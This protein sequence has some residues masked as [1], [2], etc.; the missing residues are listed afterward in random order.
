MKIHGQR[1][2]SLPVIKQ[3]QGVQQ[4]PG[5]QAQQQQQQVSLQAQ[6]LTAQPGLQYDTHQPPGQQEQAC[7][8]KIPAAD[9]RKYNLPPRLQRHG[10]HT[11]SRGYRDRPSNGG[12]RYQTHHKTR[13][14]PLETDQPVTLHMG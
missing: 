12:T 4:Q 3:E 5:P 8:A 2:L 10:Q 9:D 6:Q 13:G 11:W 7:A 14:R 1:L